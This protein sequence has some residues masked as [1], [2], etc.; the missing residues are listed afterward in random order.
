MKKVILSGL[1]LSA[2]AIVLPKVSHAE[3]K[4]GYVKTEYIIELLPEY[5][6]AGIQFEAFNKKLEEERAAKFKSIQDKAAALPKDPNA[7]TEAQ[8]E[9]VNKLIQEYQKIE[10]DFNQRKSAKQRAL[11]QPIL[12]KVENAVD[13]YRVAEGYD[14][15]L[16]GQVVKSANSKWDLSDKILKKLGVDPIAAK[17]ERDEAANKAAKQGSAVKK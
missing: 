1:L 11:V 7:M 13:S 3:M 6:N 10:E 9:E 4:I 15:I 5:K 8:K 17:K 2:S 14:L 12:T 16:E